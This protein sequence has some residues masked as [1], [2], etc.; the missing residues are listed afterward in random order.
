MPTYGQ[1]RAYET[2]GLQPA[3]AREC[4]HNAN[5][6]R[7]R[8]HTGNGNGTGCDA[9]RCRRQ[10]RM[11][12][13]RRRRRRGQQRKRNGEETDGE[14]RGTKE[15]E[16]ISTSTHRRIQSAGA[17]LHDV[18]LCSRILGEDGEA[19]VLR[20]GELVIGAQASRGDGEKE[21]KGKGRG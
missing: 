12:G 15:T 14:R 3:N 5:A 20:E 8:I 6:I 17:R 4:E 13:G 18:G 19:L 7:I 21:R 9:T 1:E 11:G 10:G 16:R 2:L